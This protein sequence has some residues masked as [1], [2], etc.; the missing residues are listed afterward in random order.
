MKK[1]FAKRF[2]A[3]AAAA[4][5]GAASAHAVE[6]AASIDELLK[7]IREAKIVE[8]RE[9]RQRE[10]EFQRAQAN[11]KAL[12][13]QARATLRQEEARST[14][15]EETF[16]ENDLKIEALRKQL[17]ERLGSLKELFGHLT[18]AAGD[19]RAI[20]RQSLVTAQYPNRADFLDELIEKMGS[21]T[22][23]PKLEEIEQL[24]ALMVQEMAESGKVVKFPAT[25]IRADGE[26]AEQEVVRVGVYNLLSDG[27]YLSY[28]NGLISEL[29]RQPA[30]RYTAGAAA[31][32]QATAGYTPVGIDPTGP[33]GGSLLKALV[34][35]PSLEEKWHQGGIVGYIITG[36]GVFALLLALWRFLVLSG[37][38]AKVNWQL[39]HPDEP[40]ENNPLGRVLK[41][42]KDNPGLDA[43][44][45]ELKLDEAVIKE[46][47]AIEAGLNLLKII[48]MVAPLLGLLGTVTGMIVTFQQITIFGAGD[49]KAMA[50]GISQAL[51]T[52]VLGLCVA[53]PTVLLHTLVNGRA[54]RVLHILEEQSAG[55]IAESVEKGEG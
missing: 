42:A 10:A 29:A 24:W 28:D 25:V 36:I 21:D 9:F 13:E 8:S 22:K 37:V 41:V 31:L 39:K 11:Q 54:Q 35:T 5:F 15:L 49:P 34:D 30:R 3:L 55:I 47:P 50:G 51:V 19:M 44:T 23:L 2:C 46:R 48:A 17:D 53:I 14:R 38:A 20:V 18:S 45:L 52:T 33:S 12:L 26:R 1:S 6:Q 43:E 4:L 27:K 32:Q 40:R 7:L 16:D